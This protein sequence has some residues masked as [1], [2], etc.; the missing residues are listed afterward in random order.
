MFTPRA[1]F[2]AMALAVAL[3]SSA[4]AQKLANPRADAPTK[5]LYT[6][7]YQLKS[8]SNKRILSGQN[9]NVRGN[10]RITDDNELLHNLK[11]KTGH[12]PAMIGADYNDSGNYGRATAILQQ[13]AEAEG[14]IVTI[15]GGLRNPGIQQGEMEKLLPGG[16]LRR[17]W[18]AELDMMATQLQYFQDRGTPVLYRPFHEMNGNWCWYYNTDGEEFKKL[19]IDQFDYLTKVKKLNNLIWVYG[20]N[21]NTAGDGAYAHYYPG[22]AYVDIVGADVYSDTM[23]IN[24]YD[25]LKGFNKPIFYTEFGPSGP[26]S[27]GPLDGKF[28]Y[29]KL[30]DKIKT[31][32]PEIVGW[33]SWH[34]WVN[35]KEGWIYKSI[36]KND[37]TNV[38]SHPWVL[39][40]GEVPSARRKKV[41]TATGNK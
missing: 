13:Y 19:W 1:T 29:A 38:F 35:D 36:A 16:S 5:S 3:S 8:R 4:H 39:D 18:L 30:A 24:D 9:F 17:E 25:V 28:D 11:V 27:K 32:Y 6:F 34:D 41:N 22:A 31:D 37:T 14:C 15:C 23:V 33:L 20:P 12:V 21:N 7:I 10:A 26:V 2:A 40:A